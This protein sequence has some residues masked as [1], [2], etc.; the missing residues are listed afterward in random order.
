MAVPPV[1]KK[2]ASAATSVG[3]SG[4]VARGV[5]KPGQKESATDVMGHSWDGLKKQLSNPMS[6]LEASRKAQAAA[7]KDNVSL[8][9]RSTAD[10][11]GTQM[12]QQVDQLGKD[13]ENICK[14]Q[15]AM[16]TVGATFAALTSLEQL[17]SAPFAAIPFPAFPAVRVFD[18]D[19]GLPHAHSHPPNLIPPA[20][21]VPLPS[22]GPIIPIPYVSGANK[23]LIN[24]MPAARC[25]DL[26]LGIWCGGFV[27]LYEVFLGSASVWIEGA[28]AARIAID[29]T[30]HCIFSARP[31]PKDPPIGSFVGMTITS[32]GNVMIGGVPMPSLTAMAMGA[33]F[34]GAFK[35]G[36][37]AAKFLAGTRFGK[38]IADALSKAGRKASAKWNKMW[39]KKSI[40]QGIKNSNMV[41][42]HA[43][44]ISN[45]AT[46]TDQ[47]LMFQHVNPK[48]KGHLEKGAATK[49]LDIHA[50]TDGDG[51]I[52]L[53]QANSPK[54]AAQGA[55][56]V[57]DQNK[58]MKELLKDPNSGYAK[59][60]AP[61][62]P[63]LG[64]KT[65]DGD[66]VPV[67]SD[68]DM[69]ATGSK[70]PA[71]APRDVPN[72]GNITPTQEKTLDKIND[73]VDNKGGNVVHHGPENQNVNGRPPP[74]D[75]PKY[76]VTAYEPDGSVHTIENAQQHKDYVNQKKAEGYNG[77]DP[78]PKWGWG[79]PGPD[80]KYK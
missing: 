59:Y 28:R 9:H 29:I 65:P 51:L 78:D 23:T 66:V 68:Y 37:K 67:T 13:W 71:E 45:V 50:K 64:K 30:N 12:S 40:K 15:G 34:K 57:D 63:Y 80:G 79:E 7:K 62:G 41:E 53:N 70:A 48:A 77:L 38:P 19:V 72:K 21:P 17:I 11:V 16:Q 47:I 69:L 33:V 46:E 31:G 4:A 55:Q 25:G 22:T 6:D 2:V 44:A 20:P 14:A 58:A 42:S 26:G 73:A 60:P 61:D 76:P 52:P 32:S 27:P 24:G 5:M 54:G 49:G 8:T 10:Q 56:W 39:W 35:L 75:G 1:V 36:G 43:K 3:G 18:L 74:Y